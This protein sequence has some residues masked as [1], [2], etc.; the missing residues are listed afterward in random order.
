MSEFS[1]FMKKLNLRITDCNFLSGK[2]LGNSPADKL[3]SMVYK[4][5][6]FS[7]GLVTAV[8]R[9]C[10]AVQTNATLEYRGACPAEAHSPM[11][12]ELNHASL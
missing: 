12:I 10:A 1:F 11:R 5:A 8:Q 9:G 4:K 3:K 7:D 2:E 6:A